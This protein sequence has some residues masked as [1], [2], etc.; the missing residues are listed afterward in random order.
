MPDSRYRKGDPMKTLILSDQAWSDLT[1][2]LDE[3]TLAR[4]L[5]ADMAELPGAEE[6]HRLAR[7][8]QTP[9]LFELLRDQLAAATDAQ[10][11]QREKLHLVMR[12]AYK[13]GVGPAVLS[14]WSGYDPTHT[15][16]ILNRR[17]NA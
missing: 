4:L 7:A 11:T 1:G 15:Y 6:L 12:E 14:R 2:A 9:K 8:K 16:E 5:A 17:E 13:Q 3:S 10:A